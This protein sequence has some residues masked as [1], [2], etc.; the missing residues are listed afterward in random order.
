MLC[1]G[2]ACGLPFMLVFNTLSAWLRQSGIDR[3]TIGMLAWVGIVVSIKFLWAPVIDRVR[4]PLLYSLLGRRRSW[5]LVGQIGVILGLV[6]LSRAEPTVS[7]LYI[8]LSAIFIAFFETTQD[9]AVDA[10]RIE[11]APPELRGVM[12][13]AYQFGYRIAVMVASAGALWIAADHG[14]HTAYLSMAAMGGVGILATCCTREPQAKAPQESVMREQRVIDWLEH[15]QHW[16]EPLRHAGAHFVSAVVTPL[17]DFFGRFGPKLAISILVF[18]STYRL[19]DYV[20]GVMANP[21]YLDHGY[22][23]KQIATVV[24]GYGLIASLVGVL[25]GGTVVARLGAVRA[26]VVGSAMV[27]LSN[28]GF[29]LLATT[30]S[31]TLLG[32]AAA[33]SL[34][35]LALGIHGTAL[36]AFLSGLTSA[37]YTATQYALLSSLYALPGKLLMGTSGFVVDAIGYSRFFLYT[38]SL[39][40]PA[41]LILFWLTRRES[42]AAL[43]ALP[44]EKSSS[45]N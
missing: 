24:K 31:P 36:V 22:T 33:N 27:M 29:S 17:I 23:L 5:M 4:V 25:V 26:L 11:V 9:I 14:W 45:V 28:I 7:I 39:S 8:A 3:A 37:S 32:L 34:D 2:F 18:A 19:T 12:A 42:H 44:Q 21:F 40:L 35:N 30:T 38:A 41:L 6:A 1:L 15:R 10:W 43:F 20:M 13:A 16:P